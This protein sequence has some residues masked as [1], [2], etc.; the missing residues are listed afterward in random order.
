[1][2][3]G[4]LTLQTRW[5]TKLLYVRTDL[6]TFEQSNS[7][8]STLSHTQNCS[9]NRTLMKLLAKSMKTKYK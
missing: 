5:Q 3:V 2:T 7:Q 4:Q 9:K 8:N 1:M 6:F